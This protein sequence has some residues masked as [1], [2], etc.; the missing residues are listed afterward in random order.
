ME[1]IN[2]IVIIP[3][4][5]KH[6]SGFMCMDF[7]AV[8]DNFKPMYRLSGCSDVL[9]IDCLSEI[10]NYLDGISNMSY[11]KQ[12]KIDC[13][14]CGYLRLFC[15]YRLKSDY[16]AVSIYNII[17]DIDSPKNSKMKGNK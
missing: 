6:D 2:S 4:K 12:W 16:C 9:H 5:E 3:T 10:R 14:P 7:V 1:D 15:N 17:A 11:P 13:L 8:D